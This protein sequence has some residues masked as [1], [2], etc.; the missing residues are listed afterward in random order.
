MPVDN[1]VSVISKSDLITT[2]PNM[3]KEGSI[4]RGEFIFRNSFM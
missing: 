1:D 4:H 2:L 3:K